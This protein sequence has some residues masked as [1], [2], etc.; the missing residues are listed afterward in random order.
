MEDVTQTH[1]PVFSATRRC[2]SVPELQHLIFDL[3]YR[4]PGGPRNLTA[5]ARTARIFHDVALNT[6]W[7]TQES[8]VPL[9]K[10]FP[11]QLWT[12]SR[13]DDGCR[14]VTLTAEP[15]PEDWTRVRLY[16]ARI[17]EMRL[18]LDERAHEKLAGDVF[19]TLRRSLVYD[20]LLPN[21]HSFEWSQTLSNN[22]HNLASFLLMLNPLVVSMDVKMST[23]DKEAAETIASAL[24][25]FGQSPTQLRS[26]T[27]QWNECRPLHEALLSLAHTQQQ[28]HTLVCTWEDDLSLETILHL[29][30]L[31]SL[32]RVS[33]C[34]DPDT[35]LQIVEEAKELTGTLFPS[36]KLLSLR[37]K[38]LDLC[39][40]LL[41]TIRSPYLD[42]LTCG[43][44]TPP[45]AQCLQDFFTRLA[46]SPLFG[47][48]LSN[49]HLI[50]QG[51]SPR[52]SPTHRVTPAT[53]EPLLR[54]NMTALQLEPGGPIDID[55]AFLERAARAWPRLRV[56]E[57]GAQWRRYPPPGQA[58][59]VTLRGL[60]P[61]A[62][63]CPDLVIL[64]LTF[65]PDASAFQERFEAN[66]RPTD[67][68]SFGLFAPFK[69]GVGASV[70]DQQ[71]DTYLLAGALSDLCP[72]LK[73]VKTA[74]GRA[75][76]GRD[77]N[78]EH[79]TELYWEDEDAE[80]SWRQI[81]KYAMEMA[82]VRRQERLWID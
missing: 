18:P 69:L 51:T 73:I 66:E 50:A 82:R 16:A 70:V 11:S 68:V 81:E 9:V 76:H 53:L 2:L 1:D 45:T 24:R 74:W 54:L 65:D 77:E 42:T 19:L 17:K 40:R 20:P 79:D 78:E 22:E 5:L 52:G 38:T 59:R 48:K 12:E 67:G 80:E 29:S 13:E 8:L 4:Q 27:F 41:G 7:G 43:F 39:E 71:A 21:L 10:C 72:G 61:L 14:T 37:C 15:K 23:W 62:M 56:L 47:S 6:L 34:T 60:L 49:I 64:G 31:N 57:L 46:S 58:V 33:I 75:Q 32:Q 35:T 36:L 26:I 55:D 28:L 25:T 44:L 63:H 3:V 30:S